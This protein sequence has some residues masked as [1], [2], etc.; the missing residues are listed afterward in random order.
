MLLIFCYL[1]IQSCKTN[2]IT[3]R[4]Q[5]NLISDAQLQAMAL[6]E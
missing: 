2:A 6:T 5:L 3:G 4:N 1:G